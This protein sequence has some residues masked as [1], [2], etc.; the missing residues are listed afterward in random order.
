MKIV[1]TGKYYGPDDHLGS[2]RMVEDDNAQVVEATMYSPYGMMEPVPNTNTSGL[3]AREKFTTKEFD[4]E[5]GS[6]GGVGDG[7]GLYYFGARYY[8]PVVGV[9][10][11]TDPKNQDWNSYQ[12]CAGNPILLV[13][14]NGEF[15]NIVGAF[16]GAMIMGYAGGVNSS[17]S[18][19]PGDWEDEDWFFAG[20]GAVQGGIWGYGIGSEID[21]MNSLEGRGLGV[22][23]PGGALSMDDALSAA[24][25]ESNLAFDNAMITNPNNQYVQASSS[26]GRYG[27]SQNPIQRTI[28]SNQRAISRAG[29]P[30]NAP[31]RA[32][33]SES[34][35]PMYDGFLGNFR[36]EEILPTGMIFDRWH[37]NLYSLRGGIYVSPY[38]TPFYGRAIP[39]RLQVVHEAYR[40]I[41]PIRGV[42]AGIAQPYFGQGGLH[43]QYKLPYRINTL[44]RHEFILP[45]P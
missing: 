32:L 27:T 26:G 2:T 39:D 1:F 6:V 35:W 16:A 8:D 43:I 15:W 3:N 11:S 20:V 21:Y 14:P 24:E 23:A 30:L 9:W 18:F 19:N 25:V 44:I 31:S 7:L 29:P 12:Y 42:Q 5:G 33:S 17:G 28:E 45:L 38:G 10:G 36:S 34:M 41:R 22:K 4:E 40:V 37:V 13:D